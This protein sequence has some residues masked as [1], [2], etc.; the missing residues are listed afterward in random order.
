MS[1][2]TAAI[3]AWLKDWISPVPTTNQGTSSLGLQRW[4]QFKEAFS[5]SFVRQ[6]IQ[7]QPHKPSTILDPFSGSGTTALTAQFLGITPTAIE[8][9]PFLADLTE[10]KL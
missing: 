6:I 7:D 2:E 10:A 5:P 3:N 4:F 8:V 9:N 1:H